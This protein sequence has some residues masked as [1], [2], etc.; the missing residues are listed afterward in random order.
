MMILGPLH[1]HTRGRENFAVVA[2]RM[3]STMDPGILSVPP[4]PH[5]NTPP[6]MSTPGASSRQGR[7]F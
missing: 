3:V 4:L 6:R 2:G 7:S 1:R 5:M